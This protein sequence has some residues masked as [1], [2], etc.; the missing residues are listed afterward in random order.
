VAPVATAES[1][2]SSRNLPPDEPSAPVIRPAVTTAPVTLDAG[3]PQPGVTHPRK[4]F[5]DRLNPRNWLGSRKPA[6][7]NANAPATPEVSVDTRYT[8]PL[9]IT[10][11]P[12]NRA[13]AQ[14]FFDDGAT[15]QRQGR[16][17]DAMADYQ[18]A[19][20]IDSTYFQAALSLGLVSIDARDYATALTS[21]DR[22][23]KLQ[24]DS[25]D[26]RYAF[27]W[28]LQK[29]TYYE[30][31][32]DELEK[33]LTQHPDQ[34]RAHLLLGNLYAQKLDKPR[35]ARDHYLRVLVLDPQ[36][37]QAQTVRNWLSQTP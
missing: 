35:L 3:A 11:I 1:P 9:P 10:P 12:G 27:A 30:D 4:S 2:A 8:Y 5:F 13:A 21:L 31:A 23:L 7:E 26:A 18:K 16:L 20:D 36:N 22:A 28:V 25:A 17:D 37:S 32:A 6:P 19:M 24:S 14:R 15:A 33:L 34:V 29:K